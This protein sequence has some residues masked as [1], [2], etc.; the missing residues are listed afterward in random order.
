[1]DLRALK[2]ADTAFLHLK[3]PDDEPLYA[4]DEKGEPIKSRPVGITLYGPGTKQYQKARPTST[5]A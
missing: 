5:G 4:L 1:M 2:V 3:G